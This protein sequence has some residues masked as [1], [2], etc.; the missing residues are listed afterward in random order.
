MKRIKLHWSLSTTT[1]LSNLVHPTK[2]NAFVYRQLNQAPRIVYNALPHTAHPLTKSYS[3]SSLTL[4]SNTP[5][6]LPFLIPLHISTL[7]HQSVQHPT[8]R[9]RRTLIL[10]LRLLQR[11]PHLNTSQQSTPIPASS[12]RTHRRHRW[13]RRCAHAWHR[14]RRWSRR[15]RWRT[16]TRHWRWRRRTR[17]T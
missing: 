9:A 15:R 2:C 3:I 16:H 8:C 6:P 13:R 12:T 5:M 11:L 7:L 17:R 1:Y 14:R 4:H 10:R